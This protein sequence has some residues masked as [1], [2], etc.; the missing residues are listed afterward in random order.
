MLILAGF[1][2]DRIS[3]AEICLLFEASNF[4]VKPSKGQYH[5]NILLGISKN[6]LAQRKCA[7]LLLLCDSSDFFNSGVS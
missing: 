5:R 7:I 3:D 4:T 2:Q 1:T 6:G